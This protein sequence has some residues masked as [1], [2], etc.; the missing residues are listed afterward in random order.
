[1]L[2]PVFG[3]AANAPTGKLLGGR[4]SP[5]RV[6]NINTPTAGVV[7]SGTVYRYSPV[8]NSWVVDSTL[9]EL[10]FERGMMYYSED[11]NELGMGVLPGK[12]F[13]LGT[14]FI[15]G[16]VHVGGDLTVDGVTYIEV[17]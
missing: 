15:P 10:P 2:T 17:P 9:T 7:G 13:P 6:P 5:N 11:T 8:N 12:L 16:D 1:V 3:L 4:Y 14:S